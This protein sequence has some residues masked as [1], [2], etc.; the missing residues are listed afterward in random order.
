MANI[1][2]ASP[3]NEFLKQTGLD[4]AQKATL[5]TALGAGT[6]SPPTLATPTTDYVVTPPSGTHAAGDRARFLVTPSVSCEL[7][8]ASGVRIPS[9]SAFTG[10]KTLTAT[11]LYIIQLEYS[12]TFWMLESLVGGY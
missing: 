12:G 9:D 3:I 5:R 11:K 8:L 10:T 7:T 6:A 1:T 4:D 2:L